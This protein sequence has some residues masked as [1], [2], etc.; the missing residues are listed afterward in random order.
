[1]RKTY[2]IT[3]RAYKHYNKFLDK[4]LKEGKNLSKAEAS[5]IYKEM[6]IIAILMEELE[7]ANWNISEVLI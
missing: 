6:L 5:L 4:K 2:E 1:M 3:L 7:K